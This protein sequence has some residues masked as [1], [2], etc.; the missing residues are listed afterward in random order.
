MTMLIAEELHFTYDSKPTI[1]EV[2]FQIR[3]GSVVGI[4]GESGCGKSTLLQLIYGLLDATSGRILW[5]SN[6]I[7]G[8]KFN[9]VPG[10]PFIKYLSQ[11]FDLMPYTTVSENIG[12]YLSNFYPNQKQNRVEELLELVDM[13]AYAKTKV[14]HLSG[15]QMQRV[16]LAKSLAVLPEILL[17]DEP[18]SHIDH[19]R[20]ND[21][22]RKIFDFTQKHRITT[23]VATHDREDVLPFSDSI[24]VM[25]NGEVLCHQP[26]SE[27]FENPKDYY[28][29]S[30]FGDCSRYISTEGKEL[31][32]FPHHWRI[33]VEGIKVKVVKCL[34]YGSYFLCEVNDSSQ[35]FWIQSSHFLNADEVIQ[36][37]LVKKKTAFTSGC[38]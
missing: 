24:M 38:E 28:I 32:T 33:S 11:H 13:T 30:L 1:Q 14:K 10:M 35:S 20:R 4:M 7:T 9:L 15:G 5:K 26:T 29:S 17:L 27:Y 37:E 18:F 22:R 6:T 21:L 2:N 25:R 8:P 34:Y 23:L 36:V 12:A 19:F 3:E 31:I 16:A